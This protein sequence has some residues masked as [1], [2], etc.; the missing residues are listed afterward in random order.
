MSKVPRTTPDIRECQRSRTH[1]AN[2]LLVLDDWN[3]AIYEFDLPGFLLTKIPYN[4]FSVCTTRSLQ[5]DV[6]GQRRPTS[7]TGR[8]RNEP[9]GSHVTFRTTSLWPCRIDILTVSSMS[10]TLMTASLLG[11]Y[12]DKLMGNKGATHSDETATRFPVGSTATHRIHAAAEL[13]TTASISGSPALYRRTSE[14]LLPE[15]HASF[16]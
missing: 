13:V 6:I 3:N 1:R 5:M 9:D 15:N 4:D 2:V 8:T 12:E 7:E 10:I 16:C 11:C 14:S